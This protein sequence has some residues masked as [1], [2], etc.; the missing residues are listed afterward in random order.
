[1]S[2][3]NGVDIF[4]SENFEFCIEMYL[5]P[6]KFCSDMVYL[7]HGAYWTTVRYNMS[8][9]SVDAV[10]MPPAKPISGTTE[11]EIS[12]CLLLTAKVLVHGRKYAYEFIN[13]WTCALTSVKY[14]KLILK[15]YNFLSR[16][17][18]LVCLCDAI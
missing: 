18:I 3:K 13:R 7:S 2:H 4:D 14:K 16:I 1:M 15:Q 11:L 6:G 9:R 5:V 8:Q 12:W 10:S 17:Y